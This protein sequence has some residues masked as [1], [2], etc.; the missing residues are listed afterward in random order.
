MADR[1]LTTGAHEQLGAPSVPGSHPGGLGATMAGTAADS[2]VAEEV[3]E[4]VAAR[5]RRKLGI[6]F[7]IAA[8]WVAFVIFLAI[9]ASVLPIQNPYA[10]GAAL[11]K[12]GPS[13]QHLLGTDDIGRDM[14]ARLIYGARVSMIV[15]FASIA[16]GMAIGGTLGLLA[17]FY[18]GKVDAFLTA[19]AN[20]LLAFPA[21][22]FA[23]AVISF[24]GQSLFNVVLVI[25]LVSIA[26][27]QR[28]VRS[29]TLNYASREFVLS[30]RA[31]GAKSSRI[32]FKEVL[33]NVVPTALSFALV[34]VGVAIV[35][36]G[37]LAFL[38]LSVPPPT[39]TWGGMINEGRN[40]LQQDPWVSLLPS[41][42]M[43]LTVL[44]LNLAGDR[45][46]AFFDVREGLL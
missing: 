20:I 39:P 9:F 37:G 23:L 5:P 46:R 36:E 41:I 21:L 30:A 42:A 35:A 17:G 6:G 12:L 11:P 22:V 44:A 3:W 32:I 43:F 28:I 38:G 2:A 15:G 1:G 26:P 29:S 8:G 24:V 31:L 45:I 19:V 40:V 7:W 25:G 10:V 14:L 13:T 18:G 27:L 34:S 33:P 4:E 16:F